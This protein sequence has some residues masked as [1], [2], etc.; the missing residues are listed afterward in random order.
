M[1]VEELSPFKYGKVANFVVAEKVMRYFMKKAGIDKR[2]YR[3]KPFLIVPN[4]CTEL[5]K[6]A[7]SDMMYQC[8]VRQLMICEEHFAAGKMDAILKEA[9][10]VI[11]IGKDDQ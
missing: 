11:V 7:F 3:K 4:A 1:D 10:A 9:S 2:K 6:K 8:K 5:E